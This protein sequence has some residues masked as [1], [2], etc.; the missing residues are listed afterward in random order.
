MPGP[1]TT[2]KPTP[3]DPEATTQYR[4]MT[5]HALTSMRDATIYALSNR[6]PDVTP[7]QRENWASALLTVDLLLLRFTAA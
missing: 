5:R 7:E 2:Q 3:I 6:G 1:A 4:A